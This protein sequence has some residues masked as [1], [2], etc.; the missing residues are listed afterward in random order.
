M[1]FLM[2]ML[3]TYE[4][5]SSPATAAA[6]GLG[7]RP[8]AHIHYLAGT[9]H[10]QKCRVLRHDGHETMPNF[11]GEWFP[12]RDIPVFDLYHTSMLALLSPWRD[13]EHIVTGGDHLAAAFE[14]FKLDK[15]KVNIDI[16]DNLQYQYECSDSTKKRR[17]ASDSYQPDKPGARTEEADID[18]SD[19][20]LQPFQSG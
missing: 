6:S 9:G 20:V 4:E 2:F 12:R 15:E 14:H 18:L 7:R 13:I 8:N 11:V 5:V 1:S 10:G 16:M 17:N 19:H 3:N